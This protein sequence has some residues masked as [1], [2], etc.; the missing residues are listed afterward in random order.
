MSSPTPSH[1]SA[2]PRLGLRL[3]IGSQML[4]AFAAVLLVSV[5]AHWL[6]L[7]Q[8]QGAAR[9]TQDANEAYEAIVTL[10]D[11]QQAV[12]QQYSA[13]AS[14]IVNPDPKV[15][16][17]YRTEG[18]QAFATAMAQA[19]AL[20]PTSEASADLAQIDAALARWRQRA[21]RDL[22]IMTSSAES[23]TLLNALTT[24]I[25]NAIHGQRERQAR[26]TEEQADAVR[27]T[28]RVSFAG[29]LVAGLISLL[30]W[31]LLNRGITRP[32]QAIIRS[33]D[34][35]CGGQGEFRAPPPSR[36][37]EIATLARAVADYR[38]NLLETQRLSSEKE[39]LTHA[40]E[41]ERRAFLTQMV[42]EFETAVQSSLT[43]AID[44]A[45]T[46]N[47]GALAVAA[48]M[49]DAEARGLAVNEATE[50]TFE[51]VRAIAAASEE[52]SVAVIDIRR[53][54]SD[55]VQ[56]TAE[57]GQE[58]LAA[59][60]HIDAL[61][62]QSAT[63][64]TIVHLIAKIADQTNLL[65]LN[66]TIEAARAGEQGRGFAVVAQEVKVLA[67]Q[68]GRATGDIGLQVAEIQRSSDQA[69]TGIRSVA[70][71][72]ERI[73]ALCRSVADSVEE[74]NGATQDIARAITRTADLTQ[75]VASN[76]GL[77]ATSISEVSLAANR[78]SQASEELN[79]SFGVLAQ[80]LNRFVDETR[81]A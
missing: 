44:A 52:L 13:V 64:G 51:D 37:V 66:A 7:G 16:P 56:M 81:S 19:R 21:D 42:S 8:L 11:V 6:A 55:A 33:L 9:A 47:R 18:P 49:R 26:R 15:L 76:I 57:A 63:I 3:G 14:Y 38:E 32:T 77:V 75:S 25:Q 35:I 50:A 36:T 28:E 69:V 41:T 78:Q 60:T 46:I 22:Q 62:Q 39:R 45:A 73:E 1:F 17:A 61:A 34:T 58:V 65:A 24:T 29:T 53:R 54:A 23:E 68:T 20:S 72:I 70:R 59:Q 10:Q 48:M 79:G 2:R 74:Q 27:M 67:T 5:A 40:N 80:R 71:V 43:D 31:F 4:S 30:V 12:V